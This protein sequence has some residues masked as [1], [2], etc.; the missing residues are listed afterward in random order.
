MSVLIPLRDKKMVIWNF[1]EEL[2][3]KHQIAI[4]NRQLPVFPLSDFNSIGLFENYLPVVGVEYSRT[5]SV[6]LQALHEYQQR[7][8]YKIK[9]DIVTLTENGLEQ[10]QKSHHDWD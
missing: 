7:G 5:D 3:S 8:Y 6:I 1:M 9:G 10:C 2:W 4:S